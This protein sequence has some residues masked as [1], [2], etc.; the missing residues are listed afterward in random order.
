MFSL[1]WVD[2]DIL[3]L[4]FVLAETKMW[5]HIQVKTV[6]KEEEAEKIL[7]K[8]RIDM[9]ISEYLLPEKS[10]IDLLRH[11]RSRHGEL[12][13]LLLTGHGN[14]DVAIEASRYGVTGYF[15]KTG[16]IGAQLNEI[17]G[18]VRIEMVRKEK[19]E[20]HKLHELPSRSILNIQQSFLLRIDLNMVVLFCNPALLDTI[21]ISSKDIV[22]ENFLN[23]II[24]SDRGPFVDAI[25]KLSPESPNISFKFRLFPEDNK[26]QKLWTEWIWTAFF[27][28]DGSCNFIQG[29]GIDLEKNL[30]TSSR[31][32]Q[33][34]TNLEFL[35]RTAM[36]LLD[37]EDQQTLYQFIGDTIL[38]IVPD[39]YITVGAIDKKN[40]ALILKTVV[41]SEDILPI[42][43]KELGSNITGYAYPLSLDPSAEVVFLKKGPVRAP[44][45]YYLLF[46]M[47]P[48]E[49]CKR[50]EEMLSLGDS[51]IL[52]FSSQ[53]EA[54]GHVAITLKKGHELENRELLEAFVSQASVACLRLHTLQELIESEER[55]KAVVESQTDVILRFRP[56]GTHI[57][58][59]DAFFT[60]FDI[61]PEELAERTIIPYIF[62]EDFELLKKHLTKLTASDPISTIEIRLILNDGPIRWQQLNIR[63]IFTP[64]G[65]LIEYQAVGRDITQRKCAEDELVKLYAE[66]E[67]KVKERTREL[68][69]VNNDLSMYTYSVTHDL[70]APLRAIDGFTAIFLEKYT[71]DLP[72]ESIRLLEIIRKN[73]AKMNQLID[74]LFFLSKS[75]HHILQKDMIHME[76]LVREVLEELLI[77]NKKRDIITIIGPIPNGYADK[78][79]IRQVFV[80]LFSNALKFT[81]SKPQ[82]IIEIGFGPSSG[83]FAYFIRDNGIGFDMNYADRIFKLFERVHFGNEYEGSGI[84]LAIVKQ[85]ID[86]HGGKIW[87]ESSPGKGS[88]FYFTLGPEKTLDPVI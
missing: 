81:R 10:G 14:E 36:K 83:E 27:D 46:H 52:G 31:E 64:D 69:S 49:K 50:I 72:S 51:Y 59:N 62:N 23:Y 71:K 43:R 37:I 55:Y 24:Q 18:I 29:I 60:Y 40:H 28:N 61:T 42:V 78:V 11:I 26:I 80:N 86:R 84:G 45:L 73:V 4:S 76:Q 82:T 68:S 63:A 17:Y 19:L 6:L 47:V 30:E 20:S 22:G 2:D 56:D 54:F 8:N 3:F 13:F 87:A 38:E 12:P 66:L 34:F 58:A 15:R 39:S 88:V 7:A 65:E 25:M 35:S 67:E 53:G 48:E 77:D 75:T 41:G 5:A 79:L 33:Y 57:F 16:D 85:I 21:H 44:S 1:L 32:E 70:R 9:V 74:S